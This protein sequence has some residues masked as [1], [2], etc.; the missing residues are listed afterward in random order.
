[1]SKILCIVLLLSVLPGGPAIVRA[2]GK[3]PD[4]RV[5]PPREVVYRK[6]GEREL[7]LFVFEPPGFRPGDRRPC[8][9][10][11]HGGGWGGGKPAWT[12]KLASW[13]ARRGMV[14]MSL[15]YRLYNRK[16]GVSVADC[17]RDARSAVRYL[18]AHAAGLGIDPEKIVASGVSAGGHLAAGTAL[19]DGIDEA[20]EDGAVSSRPAALV[21]FCPVLDTSAQGY[22]F[23]KTG[24]QWETL[25]AILRMRPGVPPTLV[26]HTK[27]DT[28]V[29]YN[30]SVAFA[31]AMTREGNLCELISYE[32]GKH[33]LMTH[34]AGLLREALGKTE[35]FLRRHGI[36]A[37][38]EEGVSGG[39]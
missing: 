37:P 8:F 20:G 10:A 23:R 28:V 14:G 33:C 38:R 11:I 21:L 16:A 12:H 22:G 26:F 18:R 7:R 9:L 39:F 4:E 1:M 17:V 15:E 24:G 30:G 19:F 5:P 6:V 31:G 13:F 35:D 2:R 36:S 32:E 27:A 3:S 29:P 34:D 25:S